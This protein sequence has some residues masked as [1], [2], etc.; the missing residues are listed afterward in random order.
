ME[1]FVWWKAYI[2]FSDWRCLKISSVVI[3][4]ASKTIMG[5]VRTC[6][7]ISGK[8]LPLPNYTYCKGGCDPSYLSNKAFSWYYKSFLSIFYLYVSRFNY[9]NA[10]ILNITN[11]LSLPP[12]MKCPIKTASHFK[13][14][15]IGVFN[16]N[17]SKMEKLAFIRT[18]NR[19]P[20]HVF[21]GSHLVVINQ[22]I[23]TFSLAVLQ[24]INQ[25]PFNMAEI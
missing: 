3:D 16:S 25:E 2:I 20:R 11:L 17:Q 15:L 5:S 14:I 10:L 12:W 21:S 23:F 8:C 1:I 4:L 7:T 22:V 9:S 19:S 13:V 6:S 24:Q 18:S